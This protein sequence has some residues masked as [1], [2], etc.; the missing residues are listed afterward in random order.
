MSSPSLRPAMVFADGAKLLKSVQHKE[1]LSIINDD[2]L[3][4]YS[5]SLLL[6]VL[7]FISRCLQHALQPCANQPPSLQ[8]LCQADAVTMNAFDLLV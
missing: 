5:E 8:C 7:F 3:S 2:R 4:L 6:K 1:L